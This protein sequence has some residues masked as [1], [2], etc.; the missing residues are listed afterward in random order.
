MKH[1]LEEYIKSISNKKSEIIETDSFPENKNLEKSISNEEEDKNQ[2][3]GEIP[4]NHGES[5]P[6][7]TF[8][9]LGLKRKDI[10]DNED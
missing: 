8:T 10:E 3:S 5:S 9:G 2:I 7:T 6:F 4:N 1:K